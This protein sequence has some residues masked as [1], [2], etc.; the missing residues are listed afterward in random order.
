LDYRY[1]LGSGADPEWLNWI[2]IFPF[3]IQDPDINFSITDPGSGSAEL[4]LQRI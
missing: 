3:G 4:N 2:L 1:V